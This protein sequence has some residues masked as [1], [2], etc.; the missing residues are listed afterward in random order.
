MEFGDS[1]GFP[2]SLL[3]YGLAA[4]AIIALVVCVYMFIKFLGNHMTSV[5][6][7]LGNLVDTTHNLTE[8]T[9]NMTDEFHRTTGE[10]QHAT[11]EV[12]YSRVV[13]TNEIKENRARMD[14]YFD[15]ARAGAKEK[16]KEEGKQVP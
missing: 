8:L 5:T 9:R 13:L 15:E 3:D 10:V 12:R 14:G 2:F 7:A 4:V 1:G 16:G 11:D 6:E